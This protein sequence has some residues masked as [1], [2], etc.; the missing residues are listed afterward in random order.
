[1]QAFKELGPLDEGLLSNMEHGDLC[2]TVRNAGHTVYLEPDSQITYAPP[3]R[4][5]EADAEFFN[6]RWSE[7]W[8]A[9]T[10]RRLTE[11]WNLTTSSAETRRSR[12]WVSDH[13]RYRLAWLHKLRK[14][15]G[16][17]W[18]KTIE[19]R[20]VAPVESAL[21]LRRFPHSQYGVAPQ[22]EARVVYAPPSVTARAA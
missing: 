8:A 14:R 9:A 17:K 20:L 2:L 19:K 21:N 11:K 22:V 16:H 7:A 4:L 10:H 18:T 12:R 15:I 13:R 3:S 5:A 6:L 1:M